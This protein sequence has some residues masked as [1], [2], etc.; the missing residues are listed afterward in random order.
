[1]PNH[2]IRSVPHFVM[3]KHVGVI[4]MGRKQRLKSFSVVFIGRLCLGTLLCTV[5]IVLGVNSW[6]G[7]VE[8]T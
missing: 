1:V 3:T 2:E 7:S 6:V 4:S 5:S 8:E